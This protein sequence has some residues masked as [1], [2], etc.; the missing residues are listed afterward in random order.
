MN[1][2]VSTLANSTTYSSF[3]QYDRFL[4]Q[5]TLRYKG[6]THSNRDEFT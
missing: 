4:Q 6:S 5:K 3:R 2:D 1:S